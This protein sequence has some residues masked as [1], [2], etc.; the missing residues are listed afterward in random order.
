VLK[1]Q[2]IAGLIAAMVA[3]AGWGCATNGGGQAVPAGVI[4][5]VVD[6]Q[7]VLSETNAGK[8][9]MESLNS[10]VKNRQALMELEERELKKM[11]EDLGRQASVLSADGKRQRE[12]QFRRRAMEFQ[13]HAN[14]MNRE[15]QDKQKEV[16][17]G[18]R[19]RVEKIVAKVAQTMGLLVV[20]EKSKGGQ[21]IYSDASLDISTKV[22]DELNKASK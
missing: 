2:P 12:E 18:F 8:K 5:G 21:T 22:V 11:E 6:P 20:I 17:E 16:M 9:A 15:V 7:K 13:Q 19:D 14:E 4:V 1:G 10:F 3:M